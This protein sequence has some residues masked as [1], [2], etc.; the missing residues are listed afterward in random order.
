MFF[1][2]DDREL[3]GERHLHRR[4]PGFI[5]DLAQFPQSAGWQT[6]F[7]VNEAIIQTR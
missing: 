1:R 4:S 3:L 7:E 2:H 6:A 5:G